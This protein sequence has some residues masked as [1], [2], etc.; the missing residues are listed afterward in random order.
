VTLRAAL[1]IPLFDDLSEPRVAMAIAAASEEAGWD[2]VFVWDH[3]LW[4][5]PV[6]RLADPWIVMAAMA[7]VTSRVA[8]GPMVTPVPRRR[9]QKLVRETVTLDRLSQGRVIFGV[10][11]G[12]DRGGEFSR[13][14]EDLDRRRRADALD[15]GLEKIVQW[16]AGAEVQGVRLLPGP[17]QRPRIPV[18]VGSR[19]P[20]RRPVRRAA[21]WDGWFP[22][23]VPSPDDLAEMIAYG[24]QHRDDG[25]AP[26]TVAVQGLPGADPAPWAAAGATWWLTR[27]EPYAPSIDHVLGVAREGPPT[28]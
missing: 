12:G 13:F 25:A 4:D 23:D 21:Q 14:G 3:M 26:W 1:F 5:P 6:E 7:T 2:G 19:F 15:E 17:Y 22:V 18:W 24:A 11:I 10:G 8:L 9:P 20:N 16:W 28:R 27:F